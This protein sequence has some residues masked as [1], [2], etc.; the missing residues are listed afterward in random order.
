MLMAATLNLLSEGKSLAKTLLGKISKAAKASLKAHLAKKEVRKPV[1]KTRVVRK[2]PAAATAVRKTRK[3][4]TLKLA[5][6]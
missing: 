2:K 4:A 1:L 5:S 6:R 3:K